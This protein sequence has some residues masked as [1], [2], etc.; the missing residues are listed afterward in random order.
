MI[1]IIYKEL[2]PVG[3]SEEN[4]EKNQL[5]SGLIELAGL[6][7]SRLD[8]MIRSGLFIEYHCQFRVNSDINI[9]FRLITE[10]K[11][12]ERISSVINII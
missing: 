10:Y 3:G 2:Y 9:N 11:I 7:V 1:K 8:D 4:Y 5:N 12:Q 6:S